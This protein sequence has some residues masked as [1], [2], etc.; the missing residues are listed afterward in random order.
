MSKPSATS[1]F[2]GLCLSKLSDA[3]LAGRMLAYKPSSFRSFNKP[4]SG[5]TGPT[6]HLGPPTEPGVQKKRHDVSLFYFYKIKKG[7]EDTPIRIASALRQASKVSW[8]RGVPWLSMAIPPKSYVLSS[9]FRSVLS[10]RVLST[11][12]AWSTTSGP[13]RV[14]LK[15]H[16]HAGEKRGRGKK[17]RKKGQDENEGKGWLRGHK[18]RQNAPIPSPGRTAIWKVDIYVYVYESLETMRV[19]GR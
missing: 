8:G 2:N 9:S 16:H 19:M 7:R 3:K 11:R 1:A 15:T 5:R 10:V 13:E 17:R 6:P 4:C 12:I 18:E 14:P